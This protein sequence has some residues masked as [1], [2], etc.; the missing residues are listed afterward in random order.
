MQLLRIWNRAGATPSAHLTDWMTQTCCMPRQNCV[1]RSSW[2]SPRNSTSGLQFSHIY[3]L[4]VALGNANF[5]VETFRHCKSL[6][7]EHRDICP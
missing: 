3:S 1:E 5:H 2:I 4:Q 7:G 6:L